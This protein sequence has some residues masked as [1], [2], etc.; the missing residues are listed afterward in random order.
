MLKERGPIPL[1][2]LRKQHHISVSVAATKNESAKSSKPEDLRVGCHLCHSGDG[3]HLATEVTGK[4]VT[5][6]S[7]RAGGGESCDETK[8]MLDSKDPALLGH[9]LEEACGFGLHGKRRSRRLEL[10][11]IQVRRSLPS[12]D[13]PR[14]A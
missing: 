12:D 1:L 10:V 14:L 11:G 3:L 5:L 13:P 7:D 4:S 8:V 6:A 9:R 2:P